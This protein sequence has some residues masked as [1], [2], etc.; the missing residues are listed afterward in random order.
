MLYRTPAGAA[1]YYSLGADYGRPETHVVLLSDLERVG[2]YARAIAKVVTPGM[3]VVD[4]GSGSGVLARLA[5]QAGAGDVISIEVEPDINELAKSVDALLAPG[6]IERYVGRIEDFYVN[7]PIGLVVSE[8]IGGLGDDEGMSSSLHRFR[9]NNDQWVG[10]DTIWVPRSL[11]V[12]ASVVELPLSFSRHLEGI[13]ATVGLVPNRV[14]GGPLLASCFEPLKVVSSDW[15]HAF[16][17]PCSGE[18]VGTPYAVELSFRMVRR[19]RRPALAFAVDCELTRDVELRTG[20]VVNPPTTWG[21]PVVPIAGNKV[22]K[23]GAELKLGLTLDWSPERGC[24]VE[25]DSRD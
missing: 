1:P 22:K 9:R 4:L 21:V 14:K 19:A 3:T 20:N 17:V 6:K 5:A 13:A 16:E 10:R 12:F 25:V 24:V 11:R 18:K 7:R 8:L 23:A 2:A 15:V